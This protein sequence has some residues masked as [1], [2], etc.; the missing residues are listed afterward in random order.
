M[1][2]IPADKVEQFARLALGAVTQAFPNK[3]GHVLTSADDLLTPAQRHPVFWGS[4]DWHSAVHSHWLLLRLLKLHPGNVVASD[5]RIYLNSA[6]TTEKFLGEA[7]YFNLDSARGFERM[8]GWAWLLQLAGELDSFTSDSD[9]KRWRENIRPLED[10]IVQRIYA[11]L[12]RLKHPIRTGVH[13][14]TSFALA[15]ALDYSRRTKN[16]KLQSLLLH[17]SRSYYAN[18]TNY[19]AQYEPSGEDFFSSA[20]N[21]ANLMRKV[22]PN[23]E[24]ID[25]LDK[26]L[27]R[28][29]I[30]G[31]K[32]LLTPVAVS[33]VTD[34][35][36]VHLAGLNLSRA[37]TL[38][39][40]A[41]ALDANP[42]QQRI[43]RASADTHLQA[44]LGYVF[45]GNFMGE[46][47]LASFAVYHMTGAGIE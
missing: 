36:L 35:R 28:L 25:W 42:D 19:P 22:M 38:S 23:D 34:G 27:P 43:L 18:D 2:E 1:P 32:N 12:P 30:G 21:E 29:G 14:D 7:E 20:L 44:G 3:P 26:F 37:W 15:F 45:S 39:G 47:W 5:I 46:H 40:I 10:V 4:F 17:H 8:Y 6:F 16:E 24:F 31:A 41:S 9:G 13:P 33:D 11:Y